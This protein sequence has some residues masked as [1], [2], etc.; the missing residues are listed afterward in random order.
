MI[1]K[2]PNMKNGS[3]SG[4]SLV[5]TAF[6]I[7]IVFIAS[8]LMLK[9]IGGTRVETSVKGEAHGSVN[10][11]TAHSNSQFLVARSLVEDVLA[12]NTN[13]ITNALPIANVLDTSCGLALPTT[14]MIRSSTRTCTDSNHS[15]EIYYGW[16]V[17]RIINGSQNANGQTTISLNNPLTQVDDTASISGPTAAP[18]YSVPRGNEYYLASLNIYRTSGATANQAPIFTLPFSFFR[19]T[20]PPA[21]IQARLSSMISLDRS[22]SML[23]APSGSIN[24]RFDFAKGGILEFLSRTRNDNYVSDNSGIGLSMFSD[25]SN[26][27]AAPSTSVR[28]NNFAS[29]MNF[30]NCMFSRPQEAGD[31]AE[32]YAS[33]PVVANHIL[34]HPATRLT[35]I[36]AG[37]AGGNVSGALVG[38]TANTYIDMYVPTVRD[39]SSPNVVDADRVNIWITDGLDETGALN[40]AAQRSAFIDQ[41]RT[42]VNSTPRNQRTTY[43]ILGI[44]D[45]DVQLLRPLAQM[46]PNGLYINVGSLENLEEGLQQVETQFQYFALRRKSQRW[47]IPLRN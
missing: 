46:T 42:W 31:A 18:E 22:T 29:T 26:I 39:P 15:K 8:A 9:L 4:F 25:D 27:F 10:Q 1:K 40:T 16:T 35:N 30:V 17:R 23:E 21:Q 43:F 19:N 32:L 5:E 34:P 41:R 14:E 24:G 11:L 36:A 2:R 3:V 7:V 6:T 45:P 33:C 37:Y 38:A 44:L 12:G 13:V 47:N 20:N 28:S